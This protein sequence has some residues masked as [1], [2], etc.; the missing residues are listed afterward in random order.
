MDWTFIIKEFG[1]IV[2]LV[3][4]LLWRESV[5]EEACRKTLDAK[6]EFIEETLVG[7]IERTTAALNRKE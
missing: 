7:L 6:D 5:R 2:G 1:P 3:F 4:F